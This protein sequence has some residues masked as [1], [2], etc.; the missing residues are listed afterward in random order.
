MSTTELQKPVA[1]IV[2]DKPR[3]LKRRKDLFNIGGFL[4]IQASSK[5][6]ALLQIQCAPA[7]DI[8]V[9]DIDLGAPGNDRGGIELATQLKAM[10]PG[11]PVV[12]YS[13]FFKQDDLAE[14]EWRT[15]DRHYAKADGSKVLDSQLDEWRI[16]ALAYRTRRFATAIGELE[17]IRHKYRVVDKDVNVLREFLAGSH[18]PSATADRLGG[19][20]SADEILSQ[21]GYKLRLVE[22]GTPRP[23]SEG[24]SVGQVMSTILVWTKRDADGF[25]AEL[26]GH[27]C[28]YEAGDTEDVAIERL[29]ILMDGFYIDFCADSSEPLSTELQELRDVLILAFGRN[30]AG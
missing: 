28:M 5:E 16:L 14:D 15:F 17:R 2:E 12:G 29:L 27:P 11:L 18:L 26:Y 30:D 10:K 6:E 9:T 8:V 23:S 13:A 1:L 24:R 3:A 4:A 22:A 7:I 19:D 20:L 21:L 25:T